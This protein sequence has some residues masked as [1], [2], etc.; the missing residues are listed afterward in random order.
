MTIKR[1]TLVSSLMLALALQAVSIQ[2]AAALSSRFQNISS[3]ERLLEAIVGKTL[4][5]RDYTLSLNADYSYEG[6]YQGNRLLGKW[7]LYANEAICL[8]RGDVVHCFAP[9]VDVVDGMSVH[10]ERPTIMRNSLYFS[11]HPFP[12]VWGRYSISQ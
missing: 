7:F 2:S 8:D 5:S 3:D 12:N 11:G 6:S 10:L 1:T 4:T 9:S